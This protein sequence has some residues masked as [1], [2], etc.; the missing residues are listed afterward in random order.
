LNAWRQKALVV[1]HSLRK[2]DARTADVLVEHMA[3]LR[4]NWRFLSVVLYAHNL[5]AEGNVIID[6]IGASSLQR[7][8]AGS[9]SS[10]ELFE[11]VDVR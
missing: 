5:L 4:V 8:G 2:A 1:A 6:L 3:L 10:E 11:V 9:Q 7:C